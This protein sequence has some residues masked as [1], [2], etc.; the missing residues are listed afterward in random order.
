MQGDAQ[1]DKFQI[2]DL[3]NG[4]VQG[5]DDIKDG[6]PYGTY[7]EVVGHY[8]S[9]A[10]GA[11]SEGDIKYRFMLGKDVKRNC[12]AERNYHYKL[13]LRLRGNANDY[14]WHIDYKE[15]DGFD[16]PNPWYISYLYNHDAIMPFKYT[17]PQG[18]KVI[19]IEAKIIENPWY[20]TEVPSDEQVAPFNQEANRA[21]GNG[22]LSLHATEK[23]V[24]TW[25]IGR[26]HV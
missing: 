17:P 7:I 1:R 24:I 22:F 10:N 3:D 14:D 13:T 15:T 25:E 11:V 19:K 23:T 8:Y 12:D 5:A 16:I 2:A 4:G 20:P 6:I 18:W 26:A 21:L 9:T